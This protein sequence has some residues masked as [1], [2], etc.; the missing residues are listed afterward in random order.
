[1]GILAPDRLIRSPSISRDT[2]DNE[3]TLVCLEGI[4]N[5]QNL[6]FGP[7]KATLNK[8]SPTLPGP[9]DP[10]YKKLDQRKTPKDP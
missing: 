5:V 2:H 8:D 7:P 6:P 1:M 9:T 3:L 10:A 4:R